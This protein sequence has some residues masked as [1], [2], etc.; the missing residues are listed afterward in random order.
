MA[1]QYGLLLVDRPGASG[2]HAVIT[3]DGP[4][5][6][7]FSPTIPTPV[8]EGHA[9]SLEDARKYDKAKD[10][11]LKLKEMSTRKANQAERALA[12]ELNTEAPA[13]AGG[14]N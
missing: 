13:G 5:P 8:G 2:Y 14:S 7:S 1:D 6:G 11:P 12:E 9:I 4:I 3:D 10:I